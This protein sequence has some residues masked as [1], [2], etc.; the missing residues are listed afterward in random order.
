[1]ESPLENCS[2]QEVWLRDGGRFRNGFILDSVAQKH[3]L[4]FSSSSLP[5]E[6]QAAFCIHSDT[7]PIAKHSKGLLEI[8][9]GLPLHIHSNAQ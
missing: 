5:P 3:A 9:A 8:G 1:M 2:Q 6:L 4:S 7:A